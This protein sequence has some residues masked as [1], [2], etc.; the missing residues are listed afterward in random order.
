MAPLPSPLST[1]PGDVNGDGLSDLTMELSI[2]EMLANGVIG[3]VTKQGYFAG[4]M[5]DGT[6]IAGRDNLRFIPEPS[7]LLLILAGVTALAFCR[8]K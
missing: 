2:S 5:L 6:V 7:S 8:R 3:L 4:E 1:A